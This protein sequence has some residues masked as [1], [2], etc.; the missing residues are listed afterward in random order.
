MW[1]FQ[2][3]ITRTDFK[4]AG[5]LRIFSV[6]RKDSPVLAPLM[7]FNCK[8]KLSL[9]TNKKEKAICRKIQ[10][11]IPKFSIHGKKE[12]NFKII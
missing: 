8:Y 4:K 5:G 10:N 6:H 3:Y 9:Q 7:C 12:K 11:I 1:L 2:F